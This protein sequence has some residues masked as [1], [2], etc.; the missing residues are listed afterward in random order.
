MV[1][2]VECLAEGYYEICG[3]LLGF[4][5]GEY[6]NASDAFIAVDVYFFSTKRVLAVEDKL[7]PFDVLLPSHRGRLSR[8]RTLAA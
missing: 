7:A 4:G 5:F 3:A 2:L 1:V 8:Y 6:W